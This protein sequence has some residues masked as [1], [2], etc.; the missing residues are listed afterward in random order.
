MG[1]NARTAI[2]CTITPAS[3]HIEETLST[4]KF[5]SRAKTIKNKPEINEVVSEEALLKRYRKEIGTLKQQL[6]AMQ[7]ENLQEKLDYVVNEKMLAEAQNE[8]Y[9]R[10][11]EEF[12]QQKFILEEKIQKMTRLILNDQSDSVPVV[13]NKVC[14]V[15]LAVS[16]AQ[17]HF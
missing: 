17:F 10:H 4:L 13:S 3:T 1:G 14:L 12:Q 9:K 11:L 6:S 7:S 2:I 5:A 16:L 8:S 15:F